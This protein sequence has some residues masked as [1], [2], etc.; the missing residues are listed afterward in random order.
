MASFKPGVAVIA[1]LSRCPVVPA[2]VV[3]GPNLLPQ[4]KWFPRGA[5]VCVRFGAPMKPHPDQAPEDFTAQVEKAVRTLLAQDA[6]PG[7]GT[8]KHPGHPLT[9]SLN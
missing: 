3:G 1:R 8:K 5:E 9:G 2:C 4:G 6:P 7:N